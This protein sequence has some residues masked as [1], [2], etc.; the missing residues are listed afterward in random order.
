MGGPTDHSSTAVGLQREVMVA[1][2]QRPLCCARRRLAWPSVVETMHKRFCHTSQEQD[3]TAESNALDRANPCAS[4]DAGCTTNWPRHK[5]AA[6][7]KSSAAGAS[8][9]YTCLLETTSLCNEACRVQWAHM[10]T[11]AIYSYMRDLRCPGQLVCGVRAGQRHAQLHLQR[12][13]N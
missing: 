8:G 4:S 11:G 3:E 6:S 9:L 2:P 13:L 1:A 12:A 10:G 5:H 7:S